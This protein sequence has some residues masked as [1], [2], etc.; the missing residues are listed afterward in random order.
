MKRQTS[1]GAWIPWIAAI[2]ELAMVATAIAL[3]R[4]QTR[5]KSRWMIMMA[6]GVL[7]LRM[8]GRGAF[9]QLAGF[10]DIVVATGGAA[11][12]LLFGWA[13]SRWGFP[14]ACGRLAPLNLLAPLCLT[15]A[16]REAWRPRSPVISPRTPL[17]WGSSPKY[18]RRLTWTSETKTTPEYRSNSGVRPAKIDVLVLTSLSEAQ[19]LVVMEAGLVGFFRKRWDL[20]VLGGL[21]SAGIW[22]DKILYWYGPGSEH[23]VGFIRMKRNY[24]IGMFSPCWRSS[25]P[26]PCSWRISRPDSSTSTGFPFR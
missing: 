14:V 12:T 8:E 24:D 15:L 21:M 9:N 17:Y 2:A 22:I 6:S 23:V 18:S 3:F 26:W 5:L 1:H 11:G 10:V 7:A 13:V 4:N 20:A 25:R 19:P 16:G